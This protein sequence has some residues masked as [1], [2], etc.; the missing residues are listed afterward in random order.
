MSTPTVWSR[1]TAAASAAR[2]SP[3]GRAAVKAAAFLRSR[4]SREKRLWYLGLHPRMK[5]RME[6][7]PH[8]KSVWRLKSRD[9]K[10][11][12][13][14][15]PNIFETHSLSDR[16][17]WWTPYASAGYAVFYAGA[18]YFLATQVL[19]R[20]WW[21]PR[22]TS[23]LLRSVRPDGAAIVGPVHAPTEKPQ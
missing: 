16:Y 10:R 11:V 8:K 1:A 23:D 3:G 9:G 5:E 12:L 14:E 6:G 2:A 22:D 17:Y 4:L 21:R 20:R 19:T 18:A 13:L 15:L 7:M